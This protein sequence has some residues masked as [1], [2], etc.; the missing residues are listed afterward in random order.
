MT[1]MIQRLTYKA[2]SFFGML[3]VMP[4]CQQDALPDMSDNRNDRLTARKC[5]VVTRS[6]P[7]NSHFERNTAYRLWA[8]K[9][10]NNENEYMFAEASNGILAKESSGRY[11]E[12]SQDNAKLLRETFNIYGFTDESK[13]TDDTDEKV[14]AADASSNHDNPTYTISYNEKLETGYPDY[15][16]AYLEYNSEDENKTSPIMEFKHILSRVRVQVIQQDNGQVS[17]GSDKEGLYQSLL[18]HAVELRGVYDTEIYNVREGTFSV[19]ENQTNRILRKVTE[20]KDIIPAE[21]STAPF[22]E[23][24]VFPTLEQ[25]KDKAL[26]LRLTIGGDDAKVFSNK[27]AG[28]GKYYIDMPL[29]DRYKADKQDN[30]NTPLVLEANHSYMLRIIFA[31]D[32]IVTFVPEVYPWFDGET[33][34][35]ENGE[36]Y[37]EQPLGNTYLFDNLIWSDRN[38]GAEDYYPDD[39]ESF[40]KCTGFFYQYGRNIPYF[41]MEI[42]E[43]GKL[44]DKLEDDVFVYPVVSDPIGRLHTP[45]QRD[46]GKANTPEAIPFVLELERINHEALENEEQTLSYNCWPNGFDNELWDDIRTQPTPPGWRL[47]TQK[48]FFGILPSTPYAGNIS[49]QRNI[50]WTKPDGEV[51]GGQYFQ[52]R[53]DVVYLNIPTDPDYPDWPSGKDEDVD[54]TD[55]A[56]YNTKGPGSSGNY[57]PEGDPYKG[58][59]SEYLIS[60]AYDDE[61]HIPK[62]TLNVTPPVL[63]T[64]YG[65]KKVGT[66]EAYRMRWRVVNTDQSLSGNY[67][68]LVIERYAATDTDRLSYDK[69]APNYYRKYDW[70]RPTAV[71]YIPIVGMIG[72]AQ[73]EE[74]SG[75]LGN[76]G[77]ETIFATSEKGGQYSDKGQIYETYKTYR[78]KLYGT[79]NRNQYLYPAADRRGSGTQIRLVRESTYQPDRE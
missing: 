31:K 13:L 79:N 59:R 64:I 17:G 42:E 61:K 5:A 2:L 62:N 32:G 46:D 45:Y 73:W 47:P 50:I 11:I 25:D 51:S 18:L 39:S 6:V 41:P 40:K 29:H 57:M 35:E 4:S 16:R 55:P 48:E 43:N 67:Y 33:E 9:L 68:T 72:E 63:G 24:Y 12:M 1:V 56:S 54:N 53:R 38:L 34:S 71:L 37:E 69:N 8:Y 23:S 58:Y 20:G 76:F 70:D 66:Q 74:R 19:F 26:I 75:K 21:A 65:I 22:S 27:E 3:C 44:V 49:F 7:P 60:K 30:Y 52:D 28:D 15:Y 78:I 14:L 36:G 10:D 77:V